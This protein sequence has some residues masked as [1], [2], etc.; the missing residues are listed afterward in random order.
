MDQTNPDATSSQR[1]PSPTAESAGKVDPTAA[2]RA[3]ALR[4]ELER[5]SYEYHVLD[6]PTISDAEYDR[7]YRELLRARR[8]SI[9][10][11][12]PPIRRRSASAPSRRA[13]SPSTR[14]SCRCC[15]SA[16]RSTKKSSRRGKSASCA[17]PATTFVASGYTCELKIDGAA[18][19]LTYHDGVFVEGTTRGNGTI[20]ESVTANLRTIRDI[21][22]RLRG[23]RPSAARWRFAAKCT[24]RS[25]R[26]ERMNEQRVARGEPVFANPRNTA[27]GAL[28]QLDPKVTASAA[29][30]LLRLRDRAAR[31]RTLPVATQSELLE[32]LASWGIPVAPHHRQCAT[33]ADVHA[34]ASEIEHTV[35]G[36]A[37]LRD[38]RRRRQGRLARALAR[39]RRRRRTRASLRDRAQVRA[40]HR[41]DDAARRS[42]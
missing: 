20:G 18:V 35:R 4:E 29:A 23:T 19:S 17:S 27:A 32:L 28:R 12:A 9:P 3:A 11:F 2:A 24:C 5:A 37:R 21:P 10:R 8:S 36:A 13:S 26:F 6:R 16:T 15:R 25:M 34:W 42:R 33:L 38:R 39:P 1:R 31:R 41:R 7:R 40:R 22:L 14:I 30:A